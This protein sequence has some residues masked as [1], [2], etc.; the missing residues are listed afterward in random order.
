MAIKTSLVR[1][2][3]W[4]T[5][6]AFD[7]NLKAR[8]SSRKPRTTF[9]ELSHPPD[10]GREFIQPGKAANNPNGNASAREKPN[11]PTSGPEVPPTY[12]ASTNKV[13][14]IGPVQ[15]KDTNAN[16]KAIKNIPINPPRS[17]FLSTLLMNELG[18]VISNAPKNEMA[19]I[20]SNK[21]K[22]TL[23]QTLVD[24]AFRASAPKITVTPKP[25]NT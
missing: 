14:M 13:P 6:S 15:E 3:N 1:M 23:N 17:A 20:T 19:N 10:C 21:K 4:S 9:T 24:I 7:K 18:S 22:P 25:S 16:V 8:A 12:A 11:I 5:R 2:P